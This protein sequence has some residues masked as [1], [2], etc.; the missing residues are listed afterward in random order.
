MSEL[1]MSAGFQNPN[2]DKSDY[3]FIARNQDG[4]G[5]YRLRDQAWTFSVVLLSPFQPVIQLAGIIP[6]ETGYSATPG[7]TN[8]IRIVLRSE[9]GEFSINGVTVTSALQVKE[10]ADG[11]AGI[12]TGL[13]AGTQ[14]PGRVI[15]YTNWTVK[16][17]AGSGPRCRS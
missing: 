15:D 4:K 13:V 1:D 2:G 7:A 12:A 3:G 16:W 5:Q 11:D 9:T 17:P 10:F 14:E 6:A 8:D